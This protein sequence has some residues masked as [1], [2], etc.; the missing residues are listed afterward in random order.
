MITITFTVGI[1]CQ[2]LPENT[3]ITFL[4]NFIFPFSCTRYGLNRQTFFSNAYK[5]VI[6]DLLY[7]NL[8]LQNIMVLFVSSQ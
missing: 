7:S 6:V 4:Q 1:S 2:L 5:V 8:L 3:Y